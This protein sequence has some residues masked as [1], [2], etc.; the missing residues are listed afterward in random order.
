M[1]NVNPLISVLLVDDD[2]FSREVIRQI[3]TSFFSHIYIVEAASGEEAIER[4]NLLSSMSSICYGDAGL[5]NFDFI[6]LDVFMPE[7][8][9]VSFFH[10]AY[11]TKAREVSKVVLVSGGDEGVLNAIFKYS[12]LLGWSAISCVDKSKLPHSMIETYALMQKIVKNK[13]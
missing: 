10:A 2:R 1:G 11:L 5:V 9:A 3:L 4:I 8:D 12:K 6:F 13:V 7:M